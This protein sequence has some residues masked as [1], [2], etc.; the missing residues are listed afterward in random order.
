MPADPALVDQLNRYGQADLLRYWEELDASGRDRLR[1]QVQQLDLPRLNSLIETHVLNP[2]HHVDPVDP[3]RVGPV[4]VE[5]LPQTDAERSARRR[6]IERGE[7]ALAEGKVAVVLVAGG[8]GTRLGFDGPKGT[9]P[10]GPVSGK[11]LFQ[12]HAEKIVAMGRKFGAPIPV[13]IM[14]SPTNHQTTLDYFQSNNQH[15]IEHLRLF[16]Q[17]QLPAVD[18]KTG[19]ILLADRDRLALSPDG[20]GGTIAALGA[21]GPQGAPSC[22]DEMK[23]RGVETIFYFQVDNPLVQICDPAYLGLHL[24]SE[25]DISFKVVE[26]L[27]PEEKVGVVVNVENKAQVIEYS[28]LPTELAERRE[29]DGHLQLWAGCIAIHC[30]D[31]AFLG[32]L[33]DGG[34]QLPVHRALKKTPSLDE[35]GTIVKPTE[36]NSVKFETFIFDA[37]PMADR[38]A[39]V[40]TERTTEFEPLKNA[41]GPDSPATVRQRMSDLYAGWLEQIGAQVTRRP[42]GTVPFGVEISPLLAL[43]PSDLKGKVSADLV[44]DRP[45]YLGPDSE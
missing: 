39:I 13:Y 3:S 16:T 14:T 44:V 10:I 25:A 45:C 40:E 32:R 31:R 42:D 12:I 33:A 4:E 41:S 17:G 11:T 5:R 38:W 36:P 43:E 37:L 23:D 7:Q 6:A 24:L 1:D 28:D 20:H 22:L 9:Y 15:G 29:P 2:A 18:A 8:Q 26:K 34:G 27:R 35:S 19:K 21:P 30:F